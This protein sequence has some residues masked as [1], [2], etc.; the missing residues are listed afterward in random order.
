[1]PAAGTNKFEE[2]LGMLDDVEEQLRASLEDAESEK[3]L[4]QTVR[5]QTFKTSDIV[6][7][8]SVSLDFLA[9]L[10]MPFVFKYL[11]PPV[12]V[13]VWSLLTEAV[14]K[15]RD[16]T[17]IALGLPRGHGKTTLIKIFI[18]FCILF[19]KRKFILVCSST[20]TLA[21]NILADVAD[22]L[23]E[24]NI[25]RVFGDW[26]M[27]MEKDTQEM[28]KFSYRGRPIIL[29]AIGAEGSMRGLNLKNERPDVMIFED[30][31]TRE[32]A[33]SKI[34]S[35]TLERWMVGTAMKAK[36]PEGCLFIFIGN[37]YPTT[38][39]ILR[40]LKDNPNW[41]KF[42]AGAILADGKALWEELQ[43]LKQL[44]RELLNDISMGH[45]EI[46]F[47]EVLNDPDA[48]STSRIDLS[49]IQQWSL[50]ERDT[51]QGK[52]ILIDPATNKKF[53]D[54]V[55]IGQFHVYDQTPALM[56]VDE[57]N[58]SPGD[59]IKHAILMALKSRTRVIGVEST[60]YQ[61]TLIYWFNQILQ[62]FGLEG[63][64]ELVEVYSGSYSKNSRIAAMLKQLGT[65]EIIV[66]PSV[67]TK[68]LKQAIEWNP[69]RRENIDGILD[70]LAYS[71]K[72]LELY[73]PM[74]A[75]ETEF[76]MDQEAA[77]AHTLPTEANSPF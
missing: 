20:A 2:E 9:S 29:A 69:L 41:I 61:Y 46:F 10:L 33:D 71:P 63:A 53:S 35:D 31:Q 23:N 8:A 18:V 73:A 67:N 27:G 65:G 11:F 44:H 39:C 58:F 25:K 4:G 75:L 54:L 14:Q 1:M 55:S 50:T 70:L 17:Q 56:E 60:A 62:Q 37:M 5:E 13:S 43:P 77:Q 38:Y 15:V 64:F 6:S 48:R 74:I 76:S 24:P 42:I 22:M 30:I 57:G 12:M 28:K 68:V 52:F 21:E 51:P 34:Q 47:A 66:H 16:F 45:P 26:R 7:A 49:K 40:K 36:S 59:T 3:L 32:N 19:T 72:M